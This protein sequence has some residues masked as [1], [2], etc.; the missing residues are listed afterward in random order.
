[1]RNK[2]RWSAVLLVASM[3]GCQ[4]KPEQAR[5]AQLPVIPAPAV[6]EPV[7]GQFFE[8]R[9][10]TPIIVRGSNP[11]AVV[12]A[13]YLADLVQRSRGFHL[14]VTQGAGSKA[15]AAIEIV[16]DPDFSLPADD[17]DEGYD[18]RTAADG[19]VLKAKT[20]HG[21]FNGAVTLWQ[22]MTADAP[23]T[24]V[25]KVPAGHIID[26][27]R[28]AW[29]GLLL[30][31]A[32]H[33]QS[34]A[35]V[36]RFIDEMARH[37][38]NILHWHLTDDQG[39]RI[40][41]RKYPK[42]TE[43]GAWRAPQPNE[44]SLVDPASG[45]YGGFYTQEQ[46]REIVRY[47]ADRHVT[48]VPEID[49]PGH[50]QA[51]IASYP[52][53]GVDGR[54]PLVSSQWGI[55]TY[56]Y[57]V[58]EATFAFIDDVLGEITDLF[59]S[60]Y[61]HVGGDEAAKD[62]WQASARVHERMHRLGVKDEAALQGYFT[63][64]LGGMLHRR[65]RRLVGWDEI[66]DGG[67]PPGAVV[68]SWRGATG[69]VAA[70][71]QGDDV[72]M[73]PDPTAYLDHLQGSGREQPPGRVKVLSLADVY[74]F[75]PVPHELDAGQARHV[76]GAQ[77]N[78]WSEY[79]TT[80]ERVELAAFP[81][82]AALAERLWSPAARTNWNDFL[83]RLPAQF[84]RYRALGTTYSDSAFAPHAVIDP[85]AGGAFQVTLAAQTGLG[86]IRY[87][88]DGSD[89][90]PHSSIYRQPLR[91]AAGR[92]VRSATFVDGRRISSVRGERIDA[93]A[94]R[95]RYSDAL[96][97]CNDSL[98]LRLEGAAD[99]SG[100]APLY[101]VDLMNPCWIYPNVD[102]DAVARIDVS[103]GALPYFFQLWHD[104]D[105]VVTHAPAGSSDEL[106]LHVDACD[107]AVLATVSLSAGEAPPRTVPIPI[108]ADTAVH[109]VHDVCLFF[110]A[111][112][113]DPLRLIEWV[114]PVA[115]GD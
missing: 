91:V 112:T 64:R 92:T 39:W 21:L 61:I 12:A 50:A 3:C 38:L 41:I 23:A 63:A 17:H 4:T 43:V 65:G 107:G 84:E 32:R 86:A 44:R 81:R 25:A 101:N 10:K 94:S 111:R 110:A 72:V 108:G 95:R 83:A 28:F 96:K 54:Q 62:Q 29:R 105:K 42:L 68:M 106:Q 79:L 80:D 115:R 113:R 70:A 69:A 56:L 57:N 20:A 13:R 18:V 82:A 9:D 51:A 88:T 26:Y 8:V 53:F 14:D 109:G 76:L 93:R 60:P 19:I 99:G 77:A 22:L 6:Y 45:K 75:E 16:L 114:E 11:E 31:S 104:T 58:D 37:K 40:E 85:V 2:A 66:L 103:V 33:F 55:N 27:P 48:I 7:T 89:P 30:D 97:T 15:G 49:M 1:M 90:G 71:G 74:A 47:A 102:F 24:P 34:A 52:Q 36:E 73:A 100:A 5:P 98:L 59:P 46:I 35:F 87:T 78:L 67:L